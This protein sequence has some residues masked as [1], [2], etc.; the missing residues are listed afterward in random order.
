MLR[1]RSTVSLI[2]FGWDGGGLLGL[3]RSRFKSPTPHLSNM[4]FSVSFSLLNCEKIFDCI[5][6]L[7]L[8]DGPTLSL[9]C[10]FL[11]YPYQYTLTFYYFINIAIP[12]FFWLKCFCYFFPHLFTIIFPWSLIL[13]IFLSSSSKNTKIQSSVFRP[14]FLVTF[15]MINYVFGLIFTSYFVFALTSSFPPSFPVI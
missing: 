11:P 9:L 8:L 1:F 12:A 5:Y 2:C 13:G 4:S 10:R 7:Y 6:S 14:I 3:D 15:M